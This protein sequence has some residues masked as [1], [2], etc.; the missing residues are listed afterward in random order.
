MDN[1]GAVVGALGTWVSHFV[2]DGGIHSHPRR[3]GGDRSPR[4]DHSRTPTALRSE[5]EGIDSAKAL[6]P[7][8]GNSMGH[9]VQTAF[10]GLKPT[11][12]LGR[13]VRSWCAAIFSGTKWEQTAQW[14]VRIDCC[15]SHEGEVTTTHI[16]LRV[17]ERD[18]QAAATHAEPISSVRDAFLSLAQTLR[19]ESPVRSHRRSDAW[20]DHRAV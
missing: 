9:P 11:D 6:S 1:R 14:Y 10:Y 17:P 20:E 3:G 4:S 19:R 13:A 16:K 12:E 8:P 2:H 15:S 18:I 5:A 7:F